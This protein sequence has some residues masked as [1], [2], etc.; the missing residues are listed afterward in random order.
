MLDSLLEDL[1]GARTDS[2][3]NNLREKIRSFREVRP[4]PPPEATEKYFLPSS[5]H[6]FL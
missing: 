5:V 1:P 2:F 6:S 3:W 4:V